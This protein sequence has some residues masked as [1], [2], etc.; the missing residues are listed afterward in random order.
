MNCITQAQ[1]D[2]LPPMTMK[3]AMKV[4]C[5]WDRDSALRKLKTKNGALNFSFLSLDALTAQFDDPGKIAVF[6]DGGRG[7]EAIFGHFDK[8]EREREINAALARLSPKDRAFARAV[9]AGKTWRDTG[10]DEKSYYYKRLKKICKKISG[11]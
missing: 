10:Y 6:S 8:R 4:C 5:K 7:E 2:A 3:E 11:K 1:L 9:L